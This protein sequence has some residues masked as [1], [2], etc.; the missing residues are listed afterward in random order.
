MAT[1]VMWLNSMAKDQAKLRLGAEFLFLV[2]EELPLGLLS[3][4]G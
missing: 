1:K 3:M 2:L 4:L